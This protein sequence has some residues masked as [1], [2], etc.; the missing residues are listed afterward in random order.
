MV[1][2]ELSSFKVQ[3]KSST[4]FKVVAKGFNNKDFEYTGE[5]KY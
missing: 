2:F 3:G 5:Y 4:P 1:T